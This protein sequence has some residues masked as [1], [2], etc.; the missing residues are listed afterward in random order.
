MKIFI[1]G[2]R[3]QLGTDA[4]EVLGAHHDVTG[5]DLPELDIADSQSA[6]GRLGAFAPDVIVNCAAYTKVDAAETERDAARRA[7]VEGPRVLAAFAAR[8]GGRLIHVSTDY[9]FDGLR[10][11]PQPYVET[12]ATRPACYYGVTKLEGERAALESGA[13]VAILRTAWMYGRQGSNF[14]KTMLRLATAD[15]R[16]VIRV[17]NDQF[18]SPTWSHRLAQQI[19]RVIDRGGEGVYHATAEG[20]CTWYDLARLFLQLMGVEHGIEPCATAEYPTPARR[21]ANSILENSRLKAA[22]MNVMAAWDEDVR[23]FVRRHRDRL[24]EEATR[25]RA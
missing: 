4:L 2:S 11:P 13:R 22:G 19:D 8:S 5:M 6:H 21:P 16:R 12:D 25:A 20:C 17:V 1:T 14:L 23:E 9:V 15:P 18:G 7:N 3:G 24:L 10:P